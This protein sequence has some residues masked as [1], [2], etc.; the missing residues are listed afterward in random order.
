MHFKHSHVTG[1]AGDGLYPAPK[2]L[3]V[4]SYNELRSA[5]RNFHPTNRIGRGGFGVV[6]KVTLSHL[7][8]P[9]FC[10]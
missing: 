10:S 4:L 3:R 8:P 5:T 1:R 2:N 7:I 9:Q 6:Y